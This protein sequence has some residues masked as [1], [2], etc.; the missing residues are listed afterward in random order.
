MTLQKIRKTLDIIPPPDSQ[1]ILLRLVH[2]LPNPL[3][4]AYPVVIISLLKPRHPSIYTNMSPTEVPSPSQSCYL[5]PL[6]LS[7]ML[8]IHGRFQ[9]VPYRYLH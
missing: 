8:P 7:I 4:P 6:N 1:S 3:A 2:D 9:I 5:F